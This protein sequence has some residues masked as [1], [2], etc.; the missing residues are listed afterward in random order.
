MVLYRLGKEPALSWSDDVRSGWSDPDSRGSSGGHEKGPGF[1]RPAIMSLDATPAV[2]WVALA[3]KCG[4]M[5][6]TSTDAGS[7]SAVKAVG[8]CAGSPVGCRRCRFP[9]WTGPRAESLL[10]CARTPSALGQGVLT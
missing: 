2:S 7:D 6:I 4:T 9:Y 10:R 8:I 1:S 3:S 5:I